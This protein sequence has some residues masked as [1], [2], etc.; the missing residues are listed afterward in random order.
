M[1]LTHFLILSLATWRMASLLTQE[2]GPWD[3]FKRLRESVG[4][5]HDEDGN[6]EM[7]PESFLAGALSCVW[8]CSV[9]V[10]FG[11]TLCWLILPETTL[12]LAIPFAIAAG[13][14]VVERSV[15]G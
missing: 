11:L 13:A 3:M 1:T 9:W 4:I 15:G 2:Y 12:I 10:A 6:V 8:C 7:V 14:V 5:E